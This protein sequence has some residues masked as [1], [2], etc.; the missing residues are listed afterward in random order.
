[1]CIYRRGGKPSPYKHQ[2]PF[3]IADISGSLLIYPAFSGGNCCMNDGISREK[4]EKTDF[5]ACG[6][7]PI[8][9]QKARVG[10]WGLRPHLR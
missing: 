3:Q 4:R 1:M 8:Q 9:A 7:V 10:A 6:R 5:R 2:K